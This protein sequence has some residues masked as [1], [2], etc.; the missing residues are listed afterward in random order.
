MFYNFLVVSKD[1]LVE[2]DQVFKE[3]NVLTQQNQVLQ[4]SVDALQK[5]QA[6]K[7]K[8]SSKIFASKL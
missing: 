2:K 1:A 7:N 5:D 4:Q 8:V 3:V 6:E